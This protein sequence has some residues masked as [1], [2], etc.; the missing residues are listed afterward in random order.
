MFMKLDYKNYILGLLIGLPIYSFSQVGVNTTNPQA[1][2][3][4]VASN[5]VAPTN[6]DG[7][8][9]PRV[10][11]FP[12]VNPTAT[13]QGM[14]VY[15]TTTVGLNVPGFYYWDNPTTTWKSISVAPSSSGW[16]LTGNAGTS[17]GVNFIGTTDNQALDFRTNNVI[18]AR[19]TTK[20]QI[21]VLN[22]GQSV[23]IGENA[24]LNDNLATNQSVFIGYEAGKENI[25]GV[26]NTFVGNNAGN[27]NTTGSGN[28][29]Y[30]R[31]A[32]NKNTSG[33]WNNAFGESALYNNTTGNHNVALGRAALSSNTSGSSNIGIGRLAL[34][35]KTIGD[36]NTVI[37]DLSIWLNS[38]GINNTTLGTNTGYFNSTGS[39]NTFL[40][41]FSGYNNTGSSNVFL[42][43]QSGY[44][45]TGSDKLYIDNSNTASPLIYGDFATNILKI[46]G[47]L[48]VNNAYNLPLTSGTANQVLQTDGAGNT[49]WVNPTTLANN[50][51]SLTG[52]SGTTSGTNFI[53]TIDNIPLTFRVNNVRSGLISNSLSSSTFFGYQSGG[54]SAAN[55]NSGFGHQSLAA[56]TAGT[57]NTAN[58]YQS[59]NINS[60]GINNT[61]FGYRT[62]ANNVNGNQNVAIGTQALVNNT[63]N[64]NTAVGSAS[65]FSNTTGNN[66]VAL[67]FNAMY[68]N[69]GG[70][71]NVAIGMESL[72]NNTSGGNNVAV[73]YRALQSNTTN[74]NNNA[75]GSSSLQNNTGLGNNAFGTSS[76]FTNVSGTG[77]VAIGHQAGY[78][79]TGSSNVFIG[80][81]SGYNET[82]SNKLYIDN[83][84]TATPLIYGDFATDL[85]R[86]N[87]TLN[88]NN[89]YNLPTT[90]GTVNQVLQTNGAGVTSWVNASS[91]TISETDPQVS[92]VTSNY[93]PKWN[94]TTLVDGQVFDNGT[95]IGIGTSTPTDKVHV[96]GNVK[97]D[98]GKLPF[99]NTGQSVFVGENAG[100]N[101]DLSNNQN[102][103]IGW[104]SGKL[105]STGNLNVFVGHGSGMVNTTGANNSAFGQF[106]LGNNTTGSNNTAIGRAALSGNTTG[107][108]NTALGLSALESN[109]SGTSN[110]SLGFSSLGNNLNGSFNTAIGSGA[111]YNNT[112]SKNV[113]IG[114]QAGFSE[115]GSDKLYIDNSNTISPLIYGDFLTNVLKVNGTLN[116]NNAYNLPTTAGAANQ[117]LQ[118]DG[119]GNTSWVNPS[120]LTITETDPQVS[121]TT[122]NY[123]PKWNGTTLVDGQVFDNGTNV[124]V[125]TATPSTH[126]HI[127]S[128]NTTTNTTIES[129]SLQ[130]PTA[131]NI[132]PST[133]ATSRRTALKLD[134]WHL[135]QDLTGTG[136]K[137]FAIYQNSTGQ[138]RITIGTTGNIG[139]GI[140]NPTEKLDINGKTK[141]TN[142]QVTNGATNGFVLQSDATGN[143]TWVNPSSLSIAETDPQVS[144][145]FTTAVPKWNGTALVDGQIY[146]NGTNVGIGNFTP[147]EKLDVYGKTKT[148]DIQIVNGAANGY[149]LKS[150]AAGNGTW[151]NPSTL[152]ITE[153]DPQVSSSGV[154]YVPRWIGTTLDDGSIQD[155]GNTIGIA[156]APVA[157]NRVTVNGKT[158]TTN[159]QITNG[160]AN[161]FVLQSDSTGNG[162]WVN[163]TSLLITETD[164]QVSSTTTN[165]IPKWNGTA[166]I[167]G[168]VFD[169]G[170]NIG[171]GTTAPTDRVHVVGNVKVDGGKLPFVNTGQSVFI[172]E[173]AGIADDLSANQNVF[174]G[175]EAGKVNTTGNLNAFV[176]FSSGTANTTGNMNT[177]FGSNTLL[178][179]TTGIN[180]VALGGFALRSISTASNNTA[181][182]TATGQLTT[183]Q[184]NTLLGAFSGSNMLN[185]NN[186]TFLGFEA[187]LN[188]VNGSNN[189]FLG[190]RAG[191]NETGSNKL[192]IDNSNTTTPLIWGD[193]NTNYVNIN[194]NLG[195]GT[196]TPIEKLHISQGDILADRG[197][198]TNTTRILTL[199]GAIS[200]FGTNFSQIDFKNFDSN[201]LAIDYVGSRISSQNTN[202]TDD[203]DLRFSTNNGTLL[204]RMIITNDGNV[205]INTF[206][207][208][209]KLEVGGKTKTLNLQITSGAV[210]GY[211]LQS[212]A[213]GNGTWVNASSLTVTE[214]DP[215]VASTTTNYMPKWNGTSLVDGQVFDNGTNVGIGTT[216]PTQAKLVV[217]GFTSNSVGNFG[218]FKNDGT[219]STNTTG[220]PYAYSIY[221]SN[222]IAASEF[223]AFSDAR[224]KNIKGISNSKSDLDILKNIEITNYTLKDSISKGNNNYKKVIAQQVEKVYPQAVS[225]ITD[226]IP[227]IYKL[228]TIENGVIVLPNGNLKVGEKIK[229]ITK[230]EEKIVTV[231]QVTNKGISVSASLDGLKEAFVYGR[232]VNDFHTVDYEALS[233]LNISATQ[234][235]LKQ[236]E[237]LK[238]RLNVTEEEN[239]KLKA[240]VQTL[241]EVKSDVEMLKKMMI[242]AKSSTIDTASKN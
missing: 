137:D 126:F 144:S 37:G 155:D 1:Q 36:N 117:I 71:Q 94:G 154:N 202:G 152:T 136:T 35:S 175:S 28:A 141:T 104:E 235:L 240:E 212:D 57:N 25:S 21:E 113:F 130:Y 187:G 46:N 3:D 139:V 216:T 227:D 72:L 81:N 62:L 115:T 186:N 135:L 133:H 17:A 33:T 160:A 22:T 118:T 159:L 52:N 129:G 169:N 98:G 29:F 214:T 211:I 217:N 229:L 234:E 191:A 82:G 50:S 85:L 51:W 162:T 158:A 228:C 109:S 122:S 40:G 225:K 111:G 145:F 200:T 233:T 103:F 197:V 102:V 203:G 75:V 23:F 198:S 184:S 56:L 223:N 125:G 68:G 61:A 180:N 224:I 210:A 127:A 114:N 106:A 100:L 195:V 220:T 8:L 64:T 43:Y 194:G 58:G 171:I 199:G 108:L 84:S 156:T 206:S 177:G 10:D 105:N 142:L 150:D 14:L 143:G 124:G 207:P 96:V 172:G 219:G 239:A 7:L 93:V 147:T 174:I 9:I 140:N 201:G 151:I 149:I 24:G 91:L 90:A 190:Y 182:G 74:F 26:G 181:I 55:G 44:N 237:A 131:L 53:G 2:L 153:T 48:N 231:L 178:A 165:Y 30:G 34:G 236:I 164:P 242:D 41:T 88:I 134:D 69:I 161:G 92:S 77:N 157:G 167:D 11:T 121:S 5:Q 80:N 16:N 39:N 208:T 63:G 230:Q 70:G 13:Q 107:T 173:N 54:N 95:N 65:M 183:G 213:T 192:Y 188:N 185:A 4:I 101:D 76:L 97:I 119:T 138:Q 18:R 27:K 110:V 166:L 60:T 83:N 176:G 241:N 59:L 168:Q 12:A 67:G 73:G 163:P 42:G 47:T 215:Q 99:V 86:V 66:N 170:T 238:E 123:I 19:I 226:V 38:N 232:Q 112:G 6:K 78:F 218:Q 179:N 221:A 193:F 196:A 189:V 204:E 148:T 205:G 128:D 116:I 87:G 32:G 45:E 89:A 222:R 132:L 209:E 15:L 79:N 49:S 20:G 31:D 146:D 120:S